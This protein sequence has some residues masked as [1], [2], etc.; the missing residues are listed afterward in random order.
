MVLNNVTR[1]TD[2]VV[3]ASTTAHTN[4]F[5]HGDLDVVHV[6]CV[7]QRF[8]QLVCK[9]QSQDV[10][11]GFFAEVVVNAED[12]V[13]RED[14]FNDCVQF[15]SSL[16]VTTKR[17]LNDNATPLALNFFRQACTLELRDNLREGAGRNGEIERMVAHS[18]ALFVQFCNCFLQ[19]IKCGVVVEFTL[20]EANALG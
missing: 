8:K 20:N 19:T 3:V 16:E 17:L 12:G 2:A 5:S 11:N 4:V 6:L 9:A 1:S 15:T 14:R 7:P 13:R 10:L 18:A